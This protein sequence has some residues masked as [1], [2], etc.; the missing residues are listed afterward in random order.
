[1]PP[2]PSVHR[3]RPGLPGYLI[4]FAPLA[5]APQRSSSPESRLRQRCSSRYLR[6]SPLHREFHFPLLYSS[7]AVWNAVRWLSHRISHTT[8]RAAYAPFTPSDS[9]QRL[10]PPYYRGCWHGVSRSLFV[11]YRQTTTYWVVAVLPSQK[12]FTPRRASSLTRRRSVRVSP[13]AEASRLLPPVGVW[14]VSQSQCG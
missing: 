1:M 12:S 9:E 5:F 7:S 2:T 8:Y 6:I 4:L 3:L 10:L 13:I 14:G 11:R